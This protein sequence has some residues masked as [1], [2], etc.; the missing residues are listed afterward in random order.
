[1]S[2]TNAVARTNELYIV[3][4]PIISLPVDTPVFNLYNVLGHD[5]WTV[6]LTIIP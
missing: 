1:M 3:L 2:I 4:V 5:G 6:L